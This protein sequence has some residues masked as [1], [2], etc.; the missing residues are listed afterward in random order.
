MP[1]RRRPL[2]SGTHGD[3][4]RL[5]AQDSLVNIVIARCRLAAGALAL[6]VL[7]A[8]RAQPAP[9][10]LRQKFE[11]AP[12]PAVDVRLLLQPEHA[13]AAPRYMTAA[14]AALKQLGE[15]LGPLPQRSLTLIDPPWHGA[16]VDAG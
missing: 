11:A 4:R 9:L 5:D 2:L 8:C 16:P 15:W 13:R 1:R 6:G 10:E 12:L 7:G 14:M 3:S